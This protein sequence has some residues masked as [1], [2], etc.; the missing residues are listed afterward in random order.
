MLRRNYTEQQ[1]P[2]TYSF[3]VSAASSA[4]D[5]QVFEAQLAIR[6]KSKKS[7]AQ[8]ESLEDLQ[9]IIENIERLT[10]EDRIRGQSEVSKA[11]T[12]QANA[13]PFGQ[14][15]LNNAEVKLKTLLKAIQTQNQLAKDYDSKLNYLSESII[16]EEEYISI[17]SSK[18]EAL[19]TEVEKETNI[20]KAKKARLETVTSRLCQLENDL[21]GL[22][23]NIQP[24]S[25][26]QA[27]SVTTHI[28][29]EP[30]T[31]HPKLKRKD[32]TKTF[33][34]LLGDYPISKQVYRTS[35]R[36]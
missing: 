23:T 3:S 13:G 8:Q 20:F 25:I 33:A 19:E 15:Y 9:L 17:N 31:H 12:A 10:E 11:N 4:L 7:S 18:I 26:E 1:Q 30:T 2:I 36:R 35:S 29:I 5:D 21:E 34:S 24:S 27:T 22:M 32:R 14:F 6:A 28:H 16:K